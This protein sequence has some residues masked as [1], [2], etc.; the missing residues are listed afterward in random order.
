MRAILKNRRTAIAAAVLATGIAAVGVT[1]TGIASAGGQSK[2][3]AP[4]AGTNDLGAYV[5]VTGPSVTIQPGQ[6]LSSSA[7]CP[8]GTV[9]LGGGEGNSGSQVL[10][11]DTR[12]S[13]TTG[14]LVYVRN[15]DTFAN[16]FNAYAICGR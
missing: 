5:V 8:S 7:S 3:A 1:G 16:T 6:Y 11:T 2:P 14:W 12:P 4:A 10:L 13:G 15:N 9:I